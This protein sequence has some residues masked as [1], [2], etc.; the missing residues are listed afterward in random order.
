LWERDP[1]Q[2]Q[3]QLQQLAT[4]SQAAQAEMRTLLLELRPA[5]LVKSSLQDLFT[6]LIQ[7]AQGRKQIALTAQVELEQALPEDVHVVLYRIAQESL[8]NVVKH[9]QATAGSIALKS[10]A[11][12]LILHIRDNGRGFDTDT[13]AAGLGLGVM[14]ERAALIG[15]TLEVVSQPGMGT[16]IMVK[17]PLPTQAAVSP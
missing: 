10:E 14:R 13:S 7:A 6:Q 4:I 11:G 5:S 12:Q 2:A 8:N 15:A 17:W 1:S 9:S 3:E 16:A